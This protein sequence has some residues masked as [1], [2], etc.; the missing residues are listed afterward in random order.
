MQNST[1]PETVQ[2]DHVTCAF[3]LMK[4][5]LEDVYNIMLEQGTIVTS[6]VLGFGDY[7]RV[8]TAPDDERGAALARD[9][10]VILGADYAELRYMAW[11]NDGSSG[12]RPRD[13]P[14]AV[15]TVTVAVDAQGIEPIGTM[16]RVIRAEDGGVSDLEMFEICP[17]EMA[18]ELCP[19]PEEVDLEAAKKRL[20]TIGA[21]KTV[22]KLSRERMR[23]EYEERA[24]PAGIEEPKSPAVRRVAPED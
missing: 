17:R 5:A 13:D 23:G 4:G 11:V 7:E 1:G 16:H 15:E 6:V 10:S 19:R 22:D 20:R 14:D 9:A 24:D 8:I 21:E 3:Y 12:L 2:H 18:V